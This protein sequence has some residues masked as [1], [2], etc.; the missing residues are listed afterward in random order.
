[1]DSYGLFEKKWQ[2]SADLIKRD[3][4]ILEISDDTQF[5]DGNIKRLFE[6]Y[7]DKYVLRANADDRP[8]YLEQTIGETTYKAV[9]VGD[10]IYISNN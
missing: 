7:P 2:F 5:L 9:K 8:E 4:K 1:M 10:K 3:F 6:E